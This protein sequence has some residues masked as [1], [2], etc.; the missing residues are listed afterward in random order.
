MNT[1]FKVTMRCIVPFL[2]GFSVGIFALNFNLH[3]ASEWVSTTLKMLADHSPKIGFLSNI[4]TLEAAIIGLAIPLSFAIISSIS[5]R[6]QS[7]VIL[8]SFTQELPVWLLPPLLMIHIVY[9]IVIQFLFSDQVPISAFW[10][11]CAWV[12]LI[13]CLS[14]VVLLFIFVHRLKCYMTGT[15]FL[16]EK[17]FYEAEKIFE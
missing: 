9:L 1:L 16:L 11:P 13:L 14:A 3:I 17:L 8:R 7:E 2:M 4:I 5:E 6:Y 15:D 12:G 10:K